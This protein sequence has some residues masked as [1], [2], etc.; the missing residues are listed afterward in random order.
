[1]STFDLDLLQG[2]PDDL[3]DIMNLV[4]ACIKHM[5]SQ[6]IHQWGDHYPTAEHF[7]QDIDN[8]ELWTAR[9]NGT[10][11]AV[12][13]LS[14]RQPPEWHKVVWSFPDPA[15]VVKRLAVQSTFQGQGI[16]HRLMDFAEDTARQQEC[17]SVR[18]DAYSDN[19][20][21]LALYQSR[22]YRNAGAVEFPKRCRHGY[23]FEKQL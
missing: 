21:A 13:T 11:L 23:C 16:G 5:D 3:P 1:M 9:H 14:E 12:I 15:L 17:R 8:R 18:L 7:S 6:G 10:L 20:V 19:P 22:G 2:H 4:Q